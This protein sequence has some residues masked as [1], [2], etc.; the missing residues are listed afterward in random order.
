MQGVRVVVHLHSRQEAIAVQGV[1]GVVHLQPLAR[2]KAIEVHWQGVRGSSICSHWRQQSRCKECG[3][4]SICSH[5]RRRSRCKECGP[6]WPRGGSS[7][8]I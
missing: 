7:E 4:S 5:S 2:Q 6:C 1:R 3:G 8:S